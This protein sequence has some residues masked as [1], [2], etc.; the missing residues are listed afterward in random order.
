MK[1]EYQCPYCQY[2]SSRKWNLKIHVRNVHGIQTLQDESNVKPQIYQQQK[3]HTRSECENQSSECHSIP[4]YQQTF[5]LE[6]KSRN[7]SI[8]SVYRVI[9]PYFVY[10]GELINEKNDQFRREL[11]K[12]MGA[13]IV[14]IIQSNVLPLL[15]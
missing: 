15:K 10:N 7:C 9:H 6:Q 5:K 11:F 2:I 14:S 3:F 12:K 8:P 13:E 4:E 1:G